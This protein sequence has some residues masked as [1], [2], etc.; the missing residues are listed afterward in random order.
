[1]GAEEE[2]TIGEHGGCVAGFAQAVDGELFEPGAGA[3]DNGVAALVMDIKAIA[4]Q[5]RGGPDR[6]VGARARQALSPDDVAGLE[7]DAVEQAIGLGP[8]DMSVEDDPGSDAAARRVFLPESVG[9][10]DV[11]GSAESHGDL[12]AAE[13]AGDQG[14]LSV[15]DGGGFRLQ[16]ESGGMPDFAAGG[17]VQSGEVFPQGDDELGLSLD[18]G[19]AGGA[20][21][22]V[23]VVVSGLGARGAPEFG[24]GVFVEGDDEFLGAGAEIEEHA[25]AVQH[26][27]GAIAERVLLGAEI[28]VPEFTSVEVV[29]ED[30]ETTEPGDDAFAVGDGRRGAEG[31]GGFGTFQV[32]VAFLGAGPARA[33]RAA[34]QCD[35]APLVAEALGEDH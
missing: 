34:I 17:G 23:G 29:G 27:R 32:G 31:V 3:D 18:D 2:V 6:A 30:A 28:G 11:S 21:G 4:D 15:G 1:M 26:G 33:P 13:I 19:D 5:Q 22:P 10:G 24:S 12:G 9:F 14:D 25:V 16:A 20:P 7:I 35:D 8:V